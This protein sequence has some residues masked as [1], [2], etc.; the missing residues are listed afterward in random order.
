VKGHRNVHST[1]KG[2][3]KGRLLFTRY[4]CTSLFA[5]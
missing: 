5:L 4:Y 2:S 1:Y 3:S